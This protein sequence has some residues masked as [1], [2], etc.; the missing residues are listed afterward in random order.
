MSR[1]TATNRLSIHFDLED[2]RLFVSIADAQSL[3]RGARKAFLSPAAASVRL[4]ALEEQLGSR[5]FYRG[6]RG[7]TLTSAGQT[8]LRHAHLVLRQVEHIKSEFTQHGTDCAGHIRIFANTTAVTQFL[9]EVLAGFLAARPGV[10]VDIQERLTRA[11]TRGVYDGSADLGIVAGP[12]PASGLESLHFN[13]DRLVLV[14][15]L[16]HPLAQYPD[17]AFVD[18]LTYEHIGLHEGS[19][20]Y[21]FMRDQ[22]ELHGSPLPLRVQVR[23]FEAMCRMIEAG[24]GVGIMP[25]S[26]A[27]RHKHTMRL[28]QTL[29]TDTWAIRERFMLVRDWHALPGCAHALID[30]ILAQF[31]DS[32]DVPAALS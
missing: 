28:A 4:K 14:T 9:P 21:A 29:L 6:N 16:G 1:N 5:L 8:L 18:T 32:C 23:S 20:L 31:D 26:A 11:I 19:T 13:T 27:N 10:T 3:T 7:V 22:S 30:A 12:A 15:P 2:L 25:E 17:A 24:V